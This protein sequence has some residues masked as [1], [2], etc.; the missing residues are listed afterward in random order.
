MKVNERY[1]GGNYCLKS[2]LHLRHERQL[3]QWEKKCP[4]NVSVSISAFVWAILIQFFCFCF[5][6]S[7]LICQFVDKTRGRKGLI[8][9]DGIL[10]IELLQFLSCTS[11]HH[12]IS[13]VFFLSF[14]VL[15]CVLCNVNA[16]MYADFT[17]Q[18]EQ[19]L[20][21]LTFKSKIAKIM[22]VMSLKY[23]PVTQSILC[24][25]FLMCVA[26]MHHKTTVHKSKNNLQLMF[27]TYLWPW[28]MV[29]VIKPVINCLTSSKFIIMQN[30]KDLL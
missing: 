6:W 28:N 7:E 30:L 13:L 16:W 19:T 24:L 2:P 22:L 18:E 4:L 12:S 27:L 25:N 29:E 23:T 15:T 21:W 3:K 10:Y 14:S 17:K 11:F 26:T 5:L 1:R 20:R 9:N 8:I